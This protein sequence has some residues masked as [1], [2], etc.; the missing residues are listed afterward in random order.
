MDQ[1]NLSA[2]FSSSYREAKDRFLE[3]AKKL[4]AYVVSLPLKGYVGRNGEELSTDIAWF[5]S[6]TPNKVL[7]H[8]SGVH[9]VEGFAGSAIQL[10][11]LSVYGNFENSGIPSD[12]AVVFIHVINSFGMSWLRRWNENNVDLNR[13]FIPTQDWEIIS[14][15][16]NDAY[17]E[18]NDFI[19]PKEE[20]F[21]WDFQFYTSVPFYAGY[22]GMEMLKQVL[23]GGQ[24]I[25]PKGIFYGGNNC[26]QAVQ[27][28][29]IF[30]AKNF[31]RCEHY[32]HID[33]HTGL[34][35][36]G[37]DTL[38]CTSTS[39]GTPSTSE[40]FL[41]N[42]PEATKQFTDKGIAYNFYGGMKTG[43]M[44]LFMNVAMVEPGKINDFLF[45]EESKEDRDLRRSTT[46]SFNGIAQEFGTYNGVQVVHAL[47]TE[48]YYFNYKNIVPS[49]SPV[50]S[51]TTAEKISHD[52]H[53]SSTNILNS[54]WIKNSEWEHK[55]ISRGKTVFQQSLDY[56]KKL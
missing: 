35:P 3:E 39:D 9:G 45:I 1:P 44:C 51:S 48:N 5:G 14:K 23:A 47:R 20:P 7:F 52:P 28:I 40:E 55:V 54:F 6:R 53:W 36:Q 37:E 50:S 33:V 56:L 25:Y 16:K 42:F 32:L 24:Y 18:L 8:S 27:N 10:Y 29:L 12:T 11:L 30:L 19:N 17:A 41:Q 43:L 31:S 21:S 4:G 49:S 15:K 22:Y 13:N 2:F 46:K 26:E 38:L 34:G